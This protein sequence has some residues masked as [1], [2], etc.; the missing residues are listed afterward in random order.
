[1]KD[2]NINGHFER[3]AR[4]VW[5]LYKTLTGSKPLKD[6]TRDDG[7]K[8]VAHFEGKGLKSA[9]VQKKVGWLNAAVNLAIDERPIEVQS[10]LENC[11]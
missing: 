11:P 7:R 1:M 9:T 5:A 4:G 3:E 2:K 10:V 8:L 6:A